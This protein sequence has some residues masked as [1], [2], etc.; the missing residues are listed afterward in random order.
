MAQIVA[1]PKDRLREVLT[2]AVETKDASFGNGR[3]VRN[4]FETV[5]ENQANRLAYEP[6]ISPEILSTIEA[7]DI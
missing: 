7:S 5:I 1:K 6:N 3:F 4:L 2:N